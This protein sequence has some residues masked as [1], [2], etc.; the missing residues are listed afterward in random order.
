MPDE[1]W[2][3]KVQWPDLRNLNNGQQ[4]SELSSKAVHQLFN[5]LNDAIIYLYYTGG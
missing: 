2:D 1:Q 5:V 3:T 4:L